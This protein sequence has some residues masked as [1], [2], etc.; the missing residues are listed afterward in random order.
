MKTIIDV[1][2]VIYGGHNGSD[3]RLKGFPI[4]GLRKLFGIINASLPC[5]DV[6]L[7]FDCGCELKKELCPDYKA[8]RI[9]DYS[10]YAQID[11]LKEL[12]T[13]C[14]IPY[15]CI[16]GY[17]ADDII[18][19]ICKYLADIGDTESVE[20]YTDDR[21]ISCC[22]TESNS[23]R[24]V[25][26]KGACINKDNYCDR[27]VSSRVIDY[28]TIL[29]WKVFHGDSSDAYKGVHV[30]GLNYDS[31]SNEFL[32]SLKPLINPQGFTEMAYADYNIYSAIV[33]ELGD[34]ITAQD[35]KVLL[36]QGRLVYP[37][38]L[39]VI[40]CDMSVVLQELSQGKDAYEVEREHMKFFGNGTFNMKQF[41]LYC[42]LLNLNQYK[43]SG[44]VD[45]DSK[46]A[47]EFFGVLEL[48]ANELASGVVATEYSRKKRV[49]KSTSPTL[50]NMELPI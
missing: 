6:A 42:A 10:V 35:K 17:E 50:E 12:L 47:Q 19:S 40:D 24:N 44:F 7:C 34:I 37:Y 41:L 36:D 32:S 13:N 28:N 49:V 2:S 23:I 22:I 38:L 4:G 25:T 21:D 16:E 45:R 11:L 3:K 30:V 43:P 26:S 48:R 5:G 46:E 39:D 1:S 9:P 20:I 18:Y 14:N 15:Y 27:V 33:D 31:F 29:L 8:G